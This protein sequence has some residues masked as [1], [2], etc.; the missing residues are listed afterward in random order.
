V[1]SHCGHD[2]VEE[3]GPNG[4][5]H[6]IR[7]GI[8]TRADCPALFGIGESCAYRIG[9]LQEAIRQQLGHERF[10]HRDLHRHQDIMRYR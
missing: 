1:L 3:L 6:K 8:A 9:H 4:L 7:F 5:D 2:E 10:E